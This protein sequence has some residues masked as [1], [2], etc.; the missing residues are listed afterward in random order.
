[1]GPLRGALPFMPPIQGCEALTSDELAVHP[2]CTPLT[3]LGVD[4][5]W[6]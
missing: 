5:P 6:T 4:D 1:M 3:P 2:Q